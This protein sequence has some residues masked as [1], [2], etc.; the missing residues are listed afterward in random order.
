MGVVL[1]FIAGSFAIWGIGDIFRS[2]GRNSVVKIGKTEIGVEQFRQLFNDRIQLLS[3]QVGRPIPMEQARN[4]GLDR[5]LL[6]SLVAEAALDEDARGMRL[7]VADA[8]ITRRITEDPAF[9]GPSGQFDR[10]RFEATIRQA[11]YT[12]PRFVAEQRRIAMRQQIV[13]AVGSG[14]ATPKN[15]AEALDRYGNEQRAI[16]Y[17]ILGRAQAGAIPS[18]TPDVLAKYFDERKALFRAPEYRKIVVLPVTLDILGKDVEISADDIKRAYEDRKA[19]FSTPEKRQVEQIV[20]RSAEEAT[21]V[22]AKLA[23]GVSFAALAKER[24]LSEKDIDL[25]LVAKADIADSAVA[26]A[27]FALKEGATSAP[28][29]G[30]FGTAIVRVS[31]IAP[32]H[33]RPFTEVENEIK[34]DIA[35]ERAKPSFSKLRDQIEDELAS[36]LHLDEVA[37][38]LKLQSR[39]IDAVDRSGRGPDGQPIADLPKTPD[40]IANAFAAE[41][42]IENEALQIPGGGF[43]WYDVIG[44]TPSRERTL[45]EVKDRVEARWRDDETISRLNAKAAELVDKLKG[46]GSMVELAAANNLKPASATGIKRQ[47]ANEA[48]SGAAVAAIFRTPK[49]Q[50]GSADAKEPV[51]RMVFRVTDVVVPPFDPNSAESKK[52][53]ETVRNSIADD[54][55]AQYIARL[56]QDV[57]VTINQGALN[58]AVGAAPVN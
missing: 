48:L 31:K 21:S 38:K 54:L 17:I 34:R 41:M 26:D 4:L 5:Q 49:G 36:G 45:D 35:N 37:N 58:Q 23:G 30:R 53:S 22:A 19:S 15:A 27:A 29:E 10:A 6:G 52:I 20:F 25:G 46:G 57:G 50:A 51:E 18:P 33:T 40:V 16:E 13:T 12:E 44:I 3:R 9:R 24:G 14:I 56:E 8:E 7:G 1:T 42:G 39:T 43:L 55:L 32:G 11:G 47:A 2:A 28:V